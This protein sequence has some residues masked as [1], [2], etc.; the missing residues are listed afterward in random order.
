MS[1]V[2]Q[3]NWRLVEFYNVGQ[4]FNVWLYLYVVAFEDFLGGISDLYLRKPQEF[5]FHY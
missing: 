5:Y 3:P 2:D 4:I 1:I